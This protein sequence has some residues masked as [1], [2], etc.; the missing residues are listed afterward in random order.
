[1]VAVCTKGQFLTK[2]NFNNNSYGIKIVKLSTKN[3]SLIWGDSKEDLKDDPSE[4]KFIFKD[5]K[6]SPKSMA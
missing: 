4:R 3:Q 2:F 1:M 5:Q 6:N